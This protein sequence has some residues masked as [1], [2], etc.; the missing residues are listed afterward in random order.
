VPGK[1]EG[2][3]GASEIGIILGINPYRPTLMEL[4]HF[5]VGTEIP[6]KIQNEYMF[7]G[8]MLEDYVADL[9]QYWDGTTDGY[10]NNKVNGHRKRTMH[11][12]NGY[13]VNEKY[14]WLFASLDRAIV[15]N[16]VM[17]IGGETMMTDC[18]LECKNI[19][20]YAS[21]L[22]EAGIPP[23]YIAQVNQQ[24]LITETNYCEI[25]ILKDGR[26]FEVI[27]FQRSEK[28]CKMIVERSYEFWQTVLRAKKAFKEKRLAER[29]GNYEIARHNEG[30][31]Q[32]LEPLPDDTEGY[33][34][35]FSEQFLKETPSMP[36]GEDDYI[37]IRSV[38]AINSIMKDLVKR[39]TLHT[40]M[41]TNT[42][43]KNGVEKL[44]FG[45]DGYIT[46]KKK[47][48]AK[49]FGLYNG[50]RNK[51][52]DEFVQQQVSRLSINGIYF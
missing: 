5:K 26:K 44:E 11:R 31:I 27:P 48:N 10:M 15:K 12:V 19:S 16:Q 14:P 47:K 23:Y 40:N 1:N 4:Y 2:G 7:H 22:W 21:R 45:K 8:L 24:M 20:H 29:A 6:N 36:G 25:A 46:F 32:Q 28:I 38:L 39:K 18:P 30:I 9:W 17:L 50:L 34:E 51:P 49:K 33:K 52:S 43:V 13:L 3:I 42:M 35:Y 41:V 37:R